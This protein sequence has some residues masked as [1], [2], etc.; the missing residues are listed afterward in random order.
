MTNGIFLLDYHRVRGPYKRVSRGP[1]HFPACNDRLIQLG[2]PSDD[3]NLSDIGGQNRDIKEIPDRTLA[4]PGGIGFGALQ[5]FIKSPHF[6]IIT[7]GARYRLRHRG[8]R[9]LR[10]A[11][12]AAAEHETLVLLSTADIFHRQTYGRVFLNDRYKRPYPGGNYR[13]GPS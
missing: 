12:P 1:F 7:E 13:K 9:R 6:C 10:F 4:C 8:L 5:N 11:R 2:F 3:G